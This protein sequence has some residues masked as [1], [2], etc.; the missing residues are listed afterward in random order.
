MSTRDELAGVLADTLNKQFKDMKVAYFLDGSDTTPTDIK[1][2]VSTGSTMLD[3][4]ISN[5][6]N[7]G[8][9]VGRITELNGLESSGK[10][11]LG[12]HMLA[13]TQKKG[14]VAVYI[15]TVEPS[16]PGLVTKF[17]AFSPPFATIV[18]TSSAVVLAAFEIATYLLTGCT[19]CLVELSM[20]HS[21]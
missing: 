20:S 16:I 2:F 11:L 21:L 7:G 9:A 6:P 19:D 3:L 8:I 18:Y 17:T 4:A 12:A 5:K 13:E 1:D 14:G 15:D 10:S